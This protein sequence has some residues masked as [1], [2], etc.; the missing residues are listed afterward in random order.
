MRLS[1]TLAEVLLV[2]FA[3]GYRSEG[4]ST[5]RMEI[6][7]GTLLTRHKRQ[8]F[9]RQLEQVQQVLPQPGKIET[10]VSILLV[11]EKK[12]RFIFLACCNYSKYEYLRD[13]R[14]LYIK[15]FGYRGKSF[16]YT[17]TTSS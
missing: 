3:L 12:T 10:F 11:E 13:S 1:G 8:L 2:L 5:W 6:E 4:S 7:N 9:R 14:G 16:I 15:Y 17:R